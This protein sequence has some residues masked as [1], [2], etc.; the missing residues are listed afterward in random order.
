M[1]VETRL[2]PS[3]SLFE[4][5][6]SRSL[7]GTDIKEIGRFEAHNSAFFQ[8]CLEKGARNKASDMRSFRWQARYHFP[9]VVVGPWRSLL[10]KTSYPPDNL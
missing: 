5:A 7:A 9:C 8:V 4:I 10:G 3:H 6:A 1:F 2:N